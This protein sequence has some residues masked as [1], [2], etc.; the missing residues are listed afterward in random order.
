MTPSTPSRPRIVVSGLSGDSGKTLV[1]L[2]L[3]L[4]ARERNL[5]VRAFKKGPDYIDAAWLRW[6]SGHPARNLDTYLMGFDKPVWSFGRHAAPQGLNVIEGNRGLFDGADSQGT[7]S[8]AALA[9]ALQAPVI[10]V[11]TATK[12]TRT[13]AACVVGCQMMDPRVQ[14]AGVVLNRIAT[15]RHERVMREAIESQCEVPVIGILPK[16]PAENLLP[17]RHLG[18]VTPQEHPRI[19][20]VRDNLLN[21]VRE[22]ID[23]DRLLEVAR[24]APALAPGEPE[25]VEQAGGSGLT[26]GYISDSAFTFYYP[27][28]LEALERAGASLLPVSAISTAAVPAGIDALY[29]GG[30]FPETHA[31]VLSQNQPFLRSLHECAEAGLPVYAECGGL[32]LLSRAIHWDG[33]RHPMAGVL[34]F[35]V[36]VMPQPQGHGY[37]DLTVDQPNPFYRTGAKLRGHEFH[38]SR[39]VPSGP[40]APT[41]CA[42]TRGTGCYP[43]R[44][45]IVLGRVWA[46]YTHIHSLATPEWA[47]ALLSAARQNRASREGLSG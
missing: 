44:D 13:V 23:L 15:G 16:A 4:L 11:L 21:L 35:E 41:A 42:V 24:D 5:P 27:E 3:L 46:S 10:L 37:A 20:E 19:G 39:I 31:A 18:L 8:T 32:M 45:G 6:A 25:P 22:H 33:Q 38:Y 12:V 7:H 17:G 36:E 1:A 26:I 30:G 47:S 34:P 14:I 43:G 40:H 9:K 2:G 28:N 29:V